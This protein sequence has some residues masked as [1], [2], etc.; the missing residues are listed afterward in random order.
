M[1]HKLKYPVGCKISWCG[2]DFE[3]L[4]NYNDYNGTVKQGNDIITN[5]Y[6][7]YQGE[8]AIVISG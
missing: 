1:G 5:F 2:E 3:V 7:C 6:F 4:E 8:E